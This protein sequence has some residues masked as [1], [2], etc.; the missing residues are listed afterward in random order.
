MKFCPECGSL[1]NLEDKICP[2][3]KF[4]IINMK[5]TEETVSNTFE[6]D[7]RDIIDIKIQPMPPTSPVAFGLME[8]I[9]YLKNYIKD[10]IM[11]EQDPDDKVATNIEN[12]AR[13]FANDLVVKALS[14]R[15]V[16]KDINKIMKEVKLLEKETDDT[17]E[18]STKHKVP[19]EETRSAIWS[20][21]QKEQTTQDA[22]EQIQKDL[23][24]ILNENITFS[25]REKITKYIN[26]LKKRDLNMIAKVVNDKI[27]SY[28]TF[29]A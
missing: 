6:P 13:T 28:R 10:S 24:D 18:Y 14:A 12:I 11:I 15:V 8:P 3:C 1:L 25:E 21:L 2:C 9:V 5:K 22:I 23:D 4:D 27:Q 17:K 19:Y 16:E 7:P 26:M 20:A 29:T